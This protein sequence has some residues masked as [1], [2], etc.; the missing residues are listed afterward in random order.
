MS[1]ESDAGGAQ[2]V[3]PPPDDIDQFIEVIHT[4]TDLMKRQAGD[5]VRSK[6]FRRLVA[7]QAGEPWFRPLGAPVVPE[8]PRLDDPVQDPAILHW[9]KRVSLIVEPLEESFIAAL[10]SAYAEDPERFASLGLSNNS[11]AWKFKHAALE[12]ARLHAE[13]PPHVFQTEAGK[14]KE[15]FGKR[16]PEFKVLDTLIGTG[17]AAIPVGGPWASEGYQEMK[18]SLEGLGSMMKS[19]GGFVSRIMHPE[20]R[21]KEK[22]ENPPPHEPLTT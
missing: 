13:E 20:L 12:V 7:S 10:R 6:R 1:F 21:R 14:L 15:T 22:A 3:G 9:L 2:V 5:L 16:D 8:D 4:A 11:A 19:V 17:L 18:G